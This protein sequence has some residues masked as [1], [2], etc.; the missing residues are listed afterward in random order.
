MV[1]RIEVV[2]HRPEW[3][4]EYRSEA[5]RITS[6]LGE[7]L[8][9]IH[10]IGSTAILGIQAKPV[11]DILVIVTDLLSILD[12]IA[13]FQALGYDHR[14]EYGIPGRQYFRKIIA[15][16][17]THH[18]HIY[19]TGHPDPAVLINF[20]DYLRD[21]PEEAQAYSRLKQKLAVRHR[22]SSVD[23]TDAKTEFITRINTLAKAEQASQK[24]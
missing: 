2:P 15:G 22:Y 19:Q 20:R 17:H 7:N 10:H 12:K 6:I 11:I 14:G 16:E 9:E 21:N 3:G 24:K 18:L 4:E 5:R 8:A 1:R 23:Y 13:D